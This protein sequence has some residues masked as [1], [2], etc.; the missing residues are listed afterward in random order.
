MLRYG[1]DFNLTALQLYNLIL[2][3]GGGVLFMER[4]GE[5]SYFKIINHKGFEINVKRPSRKQRSNK[6]HTVQSLITEKEKRVLNKVMLELG[7]DTVLEFVTMA[8]TNYLHL[9][10]TDAEIKAS[11]RRLSNVHGIQ[12]NGRLDGEL[13]EKFRQVQ[14]ENNLTQRA[15][16]YVLISKAIHL[17]NYRW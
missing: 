13:Y 9:A 3:S 17:A 11:K 1:S 4:V 15:L 14:A 2:L 8:I 10:I 5:L 7:Y 12:I 6:K 16:V